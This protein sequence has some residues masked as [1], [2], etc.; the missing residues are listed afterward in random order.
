MLW[1]ELRL[2][3]GGALDPELGHPV[4]K[5]VGMEIEDPRR[6]FGPI[7]HAIRVLKSKH[8][9]GSFHLFQRGQF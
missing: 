8:D 9:M 4:A 2:A 3:V 1:K 6:S 5:G 7:N